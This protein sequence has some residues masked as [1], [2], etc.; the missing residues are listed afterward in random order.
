[1]KNNISTA[2]ALMGSAKSEA[3]TFAARKNGK[4]GGRPAHETIAMLIR[5]EEGGWSLCRWKGDIF[6]SKNFDTA[7]EAREFAASNNYG[8]KR[9]RDCD[10]WAMKRKQY[11]VV[12]NFRTVE[13]AAEHAEMVRAHGYGCSIYE[14]WVSPHFYYTADAWLTTDCS[15]ALKALRDL[16]PPRPCKYPWSEVDWSFPDAEISRIYGIPKNTVW[17]QRRKTA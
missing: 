16:M 9:F 8:V 6:A 12:R 4:K 14:R 5:N 15:S 10:A 7:A 13:Q 2:A 1:M 3:K 17:K 11:H